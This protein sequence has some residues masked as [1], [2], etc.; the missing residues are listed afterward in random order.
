MNL[1]SFLIGSTLKDILKTPQWKRF[2]TTA[3]KLNV[4]V[5][6]HE[7]KTSK[8]FNFRS[9]LDKEPQA[10]YAFLCTEKNRGS[11][12]LERL[13][14]GCKY[15]HAGIL[16]R[17]TSSDDLTCIHIDTTGL[18][19][20][21]VLDVIDKC[22]KFTIIKLPIA[23]INLSKAHERILKAI[24]NKAKYVYDTEFDLENDKGTSPESEVKVM[25]YCSELVFDLC[26]G[27]V[28]DPDFK[29]KFKLGVKFFS[30][31]DLA[32]CGT[33]VFSE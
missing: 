10:V 22:D 25:S 32:N 29:P 17:G 4:R 11:Y 9:V 2:V 7:F 3:S 14:L 20:E 21:H 28:D 24:E 19:V 30:P 33:V 26:Y 31:D 23:P 15:S 18:R 8:Y 16:L 6:D 5:G 13:A 27:L 1:T 12:Q